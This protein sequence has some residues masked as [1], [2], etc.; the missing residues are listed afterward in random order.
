MAA[1]PEST[2]TSLLQRLSGHAREHWPRIEK[3]VTRYRAGFA[4]VDAVVNGEQIKL[5][6]LRYA[7][8]A[9]QWGF[10]VYRAS[11]DDYE[12]AYLPTGHMGGSAEDALDTAAWLYIDQGTTSGE[13]H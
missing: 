9:N 12:N 4:Y 8:Y 6:R 1:I 11:H 5:C 10:A 7:G 3:I 2:K 13:N